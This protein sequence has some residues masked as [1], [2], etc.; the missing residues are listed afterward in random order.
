VKVRAATA[1]D[2]DEVVRL[3]VMMFESMGMDA[4]SAAWQDA[5]RRHVEE[6]LGRDVAIFVV[7]DPGDRRLAAV[8]AGTIVERLPTP[9]N[10]GARTGYVQWVCTE[11]AFRGRGLAR[12]LMAWLLG[13][14]EAEGVTTIE[15]HATEAAEP[16]Y[17][18][19]GFDSSGPLAL[20]RR[21][22][23]TDG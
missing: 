5:A 7:D 11:P 21:P 6:R 1:A 10:P 19:L 13:W 16:L 9:F 18:S 14:F 4:S 22:M 17:R 12:E 8:A 15:L 23:T 20:R 2:A 3:A